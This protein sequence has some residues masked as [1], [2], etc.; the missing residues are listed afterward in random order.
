[1]RLYY[2]H[3]KSPIGRLMLTANDRALTG[4]YFSTG[5]KARKEPGP[6]WQASE[7][8]FEQARLELE[9]YFAGQRRRFEVALEPKATPFQNRVLAALNQIPYGQ[10]RSYKQIAEI[11]GSPGAV[12]AVGNANGNNPIAIFIPCHR[13]VGSN[14]ALTGFRGGL[15]AKRYLLSLEQTQQSIAGI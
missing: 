8:R 3:I 4:L 2:T 11:I 13:V 14:G 5:D 1:M 6:D 9:E 10:V 15:D 12:R 7:A